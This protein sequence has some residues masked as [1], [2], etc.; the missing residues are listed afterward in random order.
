MKFLVFG[1]AMA[2]AVVAEYLDVKYSEQS[3]A[4]GAVENNEAQNR[5]TVKQFY[6]KDG[7]SLLPAVAAAALSPVINPELVWGGVAWALVFAGY[8][9]NGARKGLKWLK[10]NPAK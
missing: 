4:R 3:F 5:P 7:L 10:A 6:I 9:F 8:H 1:V 2:V